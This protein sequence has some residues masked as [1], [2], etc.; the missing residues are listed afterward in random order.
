MQHKGFPAGIHLHFLTE[1]SIKIKISPLLLL[2]FW[3]FW[4]LA[5]LT[6]LYKIN[7][8]SLKQPE[9]RL[10]VDWT[11]LMPQMKWLAA[12]LVAVYISAQMYHFYSPTTSSFSDLLPHL[13]SLIFQTL[14]E[15]CVRRCWPESRLKIYF[16]NSSKCVSYRAHFVPV[17]KTLPRSYAVS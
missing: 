2:W 6:S 15:Q 10:V 4:S 1:H 7:T 11:L 8:K 16:W 3:H 12:R 14:E 9:W 17:C 5:R 13:Y